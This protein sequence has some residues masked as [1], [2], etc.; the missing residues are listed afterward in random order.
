M[1]AS[2]LVL[3]ALREHGQELSVR[4]QAGVLPVRAEAV[5]RWTLLLTEAELAEL[6]RLVDEVEAG[7]GR[8]SRSAVVGL[9]MG[10]LPEAR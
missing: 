8:R 4:A 7:L 6:D 1:S 2:A 9:L 10:E 5:K 3:A